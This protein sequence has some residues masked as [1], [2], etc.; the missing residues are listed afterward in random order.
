MEGEVVRD[1]LLAAANWVSGCSVRRMR[2]CPAERASHVAHGRR[3]VFVVQRRTTLLTTLKGFDASEMLP[4]GTSRSASGDQPDAE[5]LAFRENF[6]GSD[7]ALWS[8]AGHCPPR[9]RV[10]SPECSSSDL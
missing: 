7:R 3:S 1:A 8:P 9:A 4:V 10:H 5:V 2:G 6:E